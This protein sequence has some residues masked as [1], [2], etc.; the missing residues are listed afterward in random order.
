VLLLGNIVYKGKI[1]DDFEGFDDNV[2]FKMANGSY[3]IQTQYHYWYH[4][5]YRPDALITEESGRCMLTVAGHSIPVRRLSTVIESQID[6][7]F[8]GWD[9]K[10]QYKL[11]NGQIWKQVEYKYEYKYAYRPEAIV[12]DVGGEFKMSVEGTTVSVRRI[13]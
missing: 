8:T 5:A 6:G 1:D 11:L 3:W 4:Y 2:I 9:G 10:K 12:Y 7:E 13:Q